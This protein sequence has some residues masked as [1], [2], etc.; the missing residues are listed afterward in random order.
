VSSCNQHHKE[1]NEE[2]VGKCSKPM[3]C[4]GCPAGFCDRDAYGKVLPERV[5]F[6]WENGRKISIY[7]PH[8]ACPEHGGPLAKKEASDVYGDI[9]DYMPADMGGDGEIGGDS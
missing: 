8:L 9:D 7:V 2:G 4:G 6:H 1:L 5:A 3:W